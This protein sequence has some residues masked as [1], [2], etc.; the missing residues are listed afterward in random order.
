ML[1]LFPCHYKELPSYVAFHGHPKLMVFANHILPPLFRPIEFLQDTLKPLD[2][3]TRK[4]MVDLKYFPF[5]LTLMSS[6]YP[7]NPTSN[8]LLSV[9][10]NFL[11]GESTMTSSPLAVSARKEE[12]SIHT[13]TNNL[14]C[15]ES[16]LLY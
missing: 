4:V 13:E 10:K 16:S 15:I 12:K 3:F 14:V 1:A 5:S 8:D 7:A 11:A 6:L 9:T 2:F